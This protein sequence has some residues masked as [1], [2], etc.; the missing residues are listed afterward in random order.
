[1]ATKTA[2]GT[3]VRTKRL[4]WDEDLFPEEGLDLEP[5]AEHGYASDDL[6]GE[7]AVTDWAAPWG[8]G[9]LYTVGGQ[10]A[11]P[12]TIEPLEPGGLI[13]DNAGRRY[14]RDNRG[15]FAR[16]TGG[17]RSVGED[18][19]ELKHKG[20]T[21][22]EIRD[23]KKLTDR[24]TLLNKLV[25]EGKARPDEKAEADEVKARLTDMRTQIRDRYAAIHGREAEKKI[26]GKTL[27][28]GKG[29][30]AK[31][32]PKPSPKPQ[33]KPDPRPAPS[34]REE[35]SHKHRFGSQLGRSSSQ[36]AQD[37]IAHVKVKMAEHDG[38]LEATRAKV[39]EVAGRVKAYEK[40]RQ[41]ILDKINDPH[42]D[43]LSEPE[44]A[45]WTERLVAINHRIRRATQDQAAEALAL[46]R[47]HS[48]AA[49]PVENSILLDR[50]DSFNPTQEAAISAA[51]MKLDGVITSELQHRIAATGVRPIPAG[52]EQRDYFRGRRHGGVDDAMYLSTDTVSPTV[53]HEL[54][55]SLETDLRVHRA[56]VGFI[57]A[58]CG[59][60][61]T[62]RI[63][64]N[65]HPDEEGRQDAFDKAWDDYDHKGRYVGKHYSSP[66]TEVISMGLE[67]LTTDPVK[68]ATKD[69]EY[70]K[71]MLGV[72]SGRLL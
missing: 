16:H 40:D 54:G 6:E 3:I 72:V 31:P 17:T 44:R 28:R 43:R 53:I 50:R 8:S 2:A 22:Q 14:V 33:P 7:L 41:Q 64:S 71:F 18:I 52:K 19:A 30:E 45:T 68:F 51:E 46:I 13:V 10:E 69:P 12:D 23:Y 11:D 21:P 49:G 29:K 47:E 34:P 1:M 24:R 48:A 61:Q 20:A 70:F 63:W 39:A 65:K 38:P 27:T 42:F 5:Y 37:S 25:K 9:T 26:T 55:H 60:E 57:E 56:A 59:A 58:R 66:D 15:R 35:T 36:F 4:G 67:M 32:E 62:K